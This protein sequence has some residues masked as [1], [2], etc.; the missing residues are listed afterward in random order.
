MIRTLQ[1]EAKAKDLAVVQLASEQ[2]VRKLEDEKQQAI[3]LIIKANELKI[4][5][6]RLNSEAA[7]MRDA[8]PKLATLA[9]RIAEL[10]K[11]MK[12]AVQAEEFVKANELKV[13]ITKLNKEATQKLR[14]MQCNNK[15]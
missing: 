1:A 3:N 13:E 7:L 8:A 2:N 9:G 14:E 10:E 12:K 6:E 5:L 15:A 11:Q 4:E